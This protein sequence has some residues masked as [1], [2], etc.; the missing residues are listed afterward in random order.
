MSKIEG[1]VIYCG[2]TIAGLGLQYGTIFRNGIFPHLEA[3]IGRC[4]ALGELFVP[5]TRYAEVRRQLNFDIARNMRGTK[6]KYVVFY[7]EVQKWL[8]DR[9]KKKPPQTGVNLQTHA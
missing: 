9:A 3:W 8:A 2:P 6:G 4:P 7:Q 1:Q 5:V